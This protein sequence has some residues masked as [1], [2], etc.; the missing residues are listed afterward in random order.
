L[1]TVP[2]PNWHPPTVAAYHSDVSRWSSSMVRNFRKS[3]GLAFMTYVA[4]SAPLERPSEA[5]VVGSAVHR[6]IETQGQST[7]IHVAGCDGR[8]AKTYRD[9]VQ[10]FEP[11]GRLVLTRKE[12]ERAQRTADA[13]LEPRTRSAEVGRAIL[14]AG[15]GHSEWA[16]RWEDE[17]GVPCKTL[18]DRVTLIRGEVAIGEL[19]STRDPTPAVF[20]RDIGTRRYHVQ[21]AFNAR[22]V[23]RAV[24][25]EA[26]IPAVDVP[27]VAFYWVVVG[28]SPPWSVYVCRATTR[29]MNDGEV[30]VEASLRKLAG[31]LQ[32]PT[33]ATWAHPHEL[34]EDGEIPAAEP[35]SFGR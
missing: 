2:A 27:P 15:D 10:A 24:A 34:L 12:F 11:A 32:D 31:C 14:C 33:G 25:E 1:T 3:P 17:S 7:G 6:L 9:A 26:G 30:E 35:P 8:D 16:Y 18:N 4:R 5:L 19:K 23:R 28:K 22:G 21:A 29:A 13:L 20:H